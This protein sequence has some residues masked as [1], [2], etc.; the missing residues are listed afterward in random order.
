MIFWFR[1][2]FLFFY[3]FFFLFSVSVEE[4]LILK[5]NKKISDIKIAII[6]FLKLKIIS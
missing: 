6:I 3:C 2:G 1:K 4:N 5:L